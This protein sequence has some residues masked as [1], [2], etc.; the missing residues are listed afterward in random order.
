MEEA[1]G[2]NCINYGSSPQRKISSLSYNQLFKQFISIQ[3]AGLTLQKRC[4]NYQ[5]WS[6][7]NDPEISEKGTSRKGNPMKNR[8][9]VGYN[10]FANGYITENSPVKMARLSVNCIS[11]NNPLWGNN[12]DYNHSIQG[13]RAAP[14]QKIE[15]LVG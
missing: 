6:P 9:L 5:S 15:T 13:F 8:V 10:T 7:Y 2:Q 1:S 3:K 11:T 4:E 14:I 12:N